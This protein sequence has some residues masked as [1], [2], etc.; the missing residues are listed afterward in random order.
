[1]EGVQRSPQKSPE[2]LRC[3]AL[4]MLH[5]QLEASFRQMVACGFRTDFAQPLLGT[6]DL[7]LGVFGGKGPRRLDFGGG[8]RIVGDLGDFSGAPNNL[9]RL[10]CGPF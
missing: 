7:S 9:G 3:Y 8:G 2:L 6:A 1:M 10:E 5:G 4:Q